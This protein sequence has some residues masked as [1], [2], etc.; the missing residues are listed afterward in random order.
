MVPF[1]GRHVALIKI[2]YRYI[3]RATDGAHVEVY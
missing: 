1:Y 2:E 3:L